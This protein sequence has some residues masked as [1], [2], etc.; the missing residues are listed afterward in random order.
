MDCRKAQQNIDLYIDGMLEDNLAQQL[1]SHIDSCLHCKKTLDEALRLKS[2]LG[3]LGD[4]EP[5]AGLARSAIKKAKKR[6]VYTYLAAVSGLAAAAVVIAAVL[7]TGPPDATRAPKTGSVMMAEG[8]DEAY[9]A[10]MMPMD[11]LQ[12]ECDLAADEEQYSASAKDSGLRI[13]E[14]E[15]EFAAQFGRGYYRPAS[16]P[17]G[18]TLESI[19]EDGYSVVFK[20]RLDSGGTYKFGWLL[21]ARDESEGQSK[22]QQETQITCEDMENCVEY[23]Q[24]GQHFW[25]GITDD[26]LDINEYCAAEWQP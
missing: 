13:F 23:E 3:A 6:P 10:E 2:A 17:K 16:P 18:S 5:P 20:Y 8:S 12:A 25:A 1:K 9:T 22:E 15:S 21:S 26:T 14:T 7:S 11:G 4:L 19:T 24:D